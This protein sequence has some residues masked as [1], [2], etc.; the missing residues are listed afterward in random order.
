MLVPIW[1][2]WPT[3]LS[4][5]PS[6]PLQDVRGRQPLTTRSTTLLV[7][8][9]LPDQS[10]SLCNKIKVS[11]PYGT[12]G[13]GRGANL[14][15]FTSLS[16][17]LYLHFLS[18]LGHTNTFADT[19]M[20]DIPGRCSLWQE[21]PFNLTERVLP[22]LPNS[23]PKLATYKKQTSTIWKFTFN[24]LFEVLQIKRRFNWVNFTS[25]FFSFLFFDP[26]TTSHRL[27]EFSFACNSLLT[28][29][30]LNLRHWN[31]LVAV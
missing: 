24:F 27:T 14:C 23:S 6:Q 4:N 7:L 21:R 22:E 1:F 30:D 2:I 19:Q 3:D 16:P 25:I 15:G 18:S 13:R 9:V 26:L 31:L 12:D 29:R 17:R 8:T 28:Q 20:R 11:S 10:C 5:I